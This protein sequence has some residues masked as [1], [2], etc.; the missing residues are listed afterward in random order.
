M[1]TEGI[2]YT[3]SKR[4]IIPVLLE[5]VRPLDVRTIFDGFSGTTRVSQAFKKEGYTV[6]ANDIA[7]WS[8][9]FSDC[10]L[11]NR[12]PASYYQRSID[13]LNELPGKFGWFSKY[14]GGEPNSGS[15]IHSDG[16]KRMWQLH[17]TMKLD[18]IREEIDKISKNAIEKSV[19]LTSLILAMDKVDNSVG[20]HVSYL[21]QWAPRAYNT[22]KMEVPKLVIDDKSHHV[23]NNDIFDLLDDIEVDLAYYDPPYGS[24]NELMPP[25]RVRYASYYH[26]WKTICL[27]DK[28]KVVGAAHRREDV[29]DVIAGSVFEEFR[30]NA[31]GRYIVIDA[32]KRLIEETKAKYIVLSYNNNGRA[33]FDAIIEILR[34]LKMECSIIEMDYK[35]N[36][37]ATMTWT[38]QWL[39]GGNGQ[40]IRN[41]EFLF[42]IQKEKTVRPVFEF[43]MKKISLRE[44]LVDH[45]Q[46]ALF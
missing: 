19:L 17:N 43:S 14:Y 7:I 3:G 15:A 33:T 45:R 6:Y 20:H 27:N 8:K 37:M 32:L 44:P 16:K 24:S 39:N 25:S 22:M 46:R 31:E 4:E 30:K 18:A 38:N 2:K 10:Y 26:I 9:V 28:P 23:F 5:F 41:K 21:K 29:S 42:L 34:E 40:D 35:K 36:V 1:E 12:K 11:L 13:L